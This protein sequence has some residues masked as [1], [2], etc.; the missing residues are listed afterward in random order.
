MRPRSIR[1]QDELKEG[2]DDG[3]A[4]AAKLVPLVRLL[5]RQQAAE[6]FDQRDCATGDALR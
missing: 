3:N 4:L 5:A 6:E 2:K 1:R